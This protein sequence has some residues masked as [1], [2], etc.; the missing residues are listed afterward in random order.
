METFTTK[1]GKI[2][3]IRLVFDTSGLRKLMQP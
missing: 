1:E 2:S 3:Q